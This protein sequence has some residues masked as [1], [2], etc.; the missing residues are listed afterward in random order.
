MP[1]FNN[2]MTNFL[3]LIR[4][5]FPPFFPQTDATKIKLSVFFLLSIFKCTKYES[6]DAAVLDSYISSLYFNLSNGREVDRA[7]RCVIIE[8]YSTYL[9]C[10][11]NRF[12]RK[13]RS[14]R[15]DKISDDE[16]S[17]SDLFSTFF[18]ISVGFS[19]RGR[20]LFLSV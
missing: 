2:P 12:P 3:F 17:M 16:F 10:G 18:P 8:I 11:G 15:G 9:Y 19:K 1:K 20:R 7:N 6:I 5:I 4:V 14:S 13:S